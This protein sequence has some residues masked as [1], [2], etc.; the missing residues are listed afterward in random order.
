MYICF[1]VVEGWRTTL[2]YK[3]IISL[4]LFCKGLK[5]L[6]CVREVDGGRRDRLLYWPII[7][8]SL[9]YSTHCFIFKTPLS[10]SS[11]SQPCI[12][13][14]WPSV[15]YRPL[16]CSQWLKA[17]SDSALTDPN[18]NRHHHISFH[19]TYNFQLGHMIFFCFFTLVHL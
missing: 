16:R 3:N 4:F 5:V 9:G 13:N 6:W 14:Q 17:G 18:C 2:F 19:N 8:S 10:A 7:S 12:L 11:A 15:G 1:I